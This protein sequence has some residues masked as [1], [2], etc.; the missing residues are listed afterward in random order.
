MFEQFSVYESPLG[1]IGSVIGIGAAGIAFIRW[2]ILRNK[3]VKIIVA[4]P[5]ALTLP[6]ST[7]M[8]EMTRSDFI[9]LTKDL[10]DQAYA[11][12]DETHGPALADLENKISELNRRLAN[13]EEA[14][15]Q[16]HAIIVALEDKLDRAGN[17]IGG[18]RII[19][20]KAALEQGDYSIADDIFAE[21]EAREQIA[22]QNAARAA[23][24]RGEVA[25]AQVRWHDAYT[26]YKRAVALHE[27]SDH[28]NSYARM[29]W[30]LAK[31]DEAVAVY[32]KLVALTKTEFGDKSPA[33]ATSLNNLALAVEAQGRY[34][35]AEGLYREA[36]Q[37][38]A[39]TIGTAHPDYA[40]H[41]N[42]LAGVVQEQGRYAEAEGLYRDAMQIDADTIGTAHP[43]Y[44][45]RLNNL[46]VNMYYQKKYTEARDLMEQALDIRKATLPAD[47]PEIA[48]TE[49]SIAAVIADTK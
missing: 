4:N 1:I 11:E 15:A 32:E 19:A 8:V 17:D 23:F 2:I 5:D 47:H 30:R 10:R 29:T 42:N 20:A 12:R 40:N 33:Y 49:R 35:E 25:E 36:L 22:V 24:G 9:A 14:L 31:G 7:N 3:P 28:L 39:D 18:D 21:I 45:T 26:H 41:L 37:I 43:S 48:S 34:G 16:Q 6:K 27:T 44:A 38:G 46:G 13:P